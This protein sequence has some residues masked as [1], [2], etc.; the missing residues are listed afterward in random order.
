[1]LLLFYRYCVQARYLARNL[2]QANKCLPR[3]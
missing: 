3:M 1:M 2:A